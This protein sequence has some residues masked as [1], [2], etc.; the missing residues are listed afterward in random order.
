MST[1]PMVR[2]DRELAPTSVYDVLGQLARDPSVD[3]ARITQL[4]DLQLRAEAH[5]AEKEFNAAF[6]RLQPKLPRVAKRGKINLV[7]D[8][9][10]KG[11]I[12]F[13]TL[14]DLDTAIRPL[15]T[16]EGFTLS[17]MSEATN[18]GVVRVGILRHAAGH[19]IQSRM[20][21]PADKSGGK[22]ELQGYGSSM[23][24]CD[25]YIT[26]GIF[27]IIMIDEDDNA[28]GPMAVTQ[29]QVD[30]I[31]AMLQDNELGAEYR[32]KLLETMNVKVLGDLQRVQLPTIL[33]L[34]RAKIKAK[35][36]K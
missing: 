8:G 21:L 14:Q 26:R 13:C 17:F 22:G 20:Q 1:V 2:E 25:R 5:Q 6:A 29:D 24:F 35:A 3:V 18:S 31:D 19:S 32:S 10:S 34:I 12:K 30:Q 28:T 16:E 33:S 23:S 36:A 11:T 15:Y 7:K 9:V 27:N 4:M